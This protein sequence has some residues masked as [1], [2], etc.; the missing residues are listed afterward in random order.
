MDPRQAPEIR[1]ALELLESFERKPTDLE[2]AN[3]FL[4]GIQ[5][6]DDYL[7]FDPPQS[8]RA[9]IKIKKL[10]GTKNPFIDNP[11]LAD[12]LSF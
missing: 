6:L 7:D 9:S 2:A 12:S 3:D 8:H 1:E 10:Q 4:Y 5:V 11:S